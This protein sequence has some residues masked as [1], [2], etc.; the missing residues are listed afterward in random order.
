MTGRAHALRMTIRLDAAVNDPQ[1]NAVREALRG[2]GHEDVRDVRVGKVIDIVIDAAD[3][4]EALA[5]AERMC[6]DLLAN[7]VIESWD[8]EVLEA[9]EVSEVA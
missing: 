7:P 3:P 5:R 1:G 4:R 6:R 2:L 8:I 9:S